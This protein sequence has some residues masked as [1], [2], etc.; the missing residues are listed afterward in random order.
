MDKDKGLQSTVAPSSN[1][2]KCSTSPTE[3]SSESSSS[4]SKKPIHLRLGAMT[5]TWKTTK[6]TWRSEKVFPIIV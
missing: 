4:N 5:K 1:D 3:Q 2:R 6:K